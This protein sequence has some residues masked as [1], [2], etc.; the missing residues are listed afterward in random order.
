VTA[1]PVTTDQDP[2]IRYL[3]YHSLDVAHRYELSSYPVLTDNFSPVEY[4]TARV[5]QR[6]LNVNDEVKGAEIRAVADQQLRYGSGGR[7]QV[8]DF[9][10]AEMSVLAQEVVA[11]DGT[12]T[13]RLFTSD[14]QRVTLA[15]RTDNPSAVAVLVELARFLISS[16]TPPAM[17]I[18]LVFFDRDAPARARVVEADFRA[19]LADG[20]PESLEAVARSLVRD[21]I[22]VR[23]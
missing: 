18:D 13:A 2:L 4:L 15:A 12:I 16:P 7:E 11:Q 23:S 5:L 21:L 3:Q 6:S 8:R 20:T 17:G 19:E 22:K 14:E 10:K 9:V 1:P